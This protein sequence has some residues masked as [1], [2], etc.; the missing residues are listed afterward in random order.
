MN[1]NNKKE[2][3]LLILCVCS[4]GLLWRIACVQTS[5]PVVCGKGYVFGSICILGLV[6]VHGCPP[7]SVFKWF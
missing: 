6:L 4:A 3:N 5:S 1:N 7:Y 2:L